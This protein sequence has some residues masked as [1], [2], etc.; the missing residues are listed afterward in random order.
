MH[1][2]KR[3]R[4]EYNSNNNRDRLTRDVLARQNNPN[5]RNEVTTLP[6]ELPVVPTVTPEQMYSNFEE[7]IKMATDNKINAKNSWNFA[8][9][10]YFHEMTFIREGDSINFQRASCT[11]DGCVKIYTSRVDSVASETGKLLTGLAN[12]S[13]DGA[14]GGDLDGEEG[15][16]ERRVR[17]RAHRS[18]ATLLKDF[19]S[20]VLKKLDVDFAVDPL[21]KKTSADF[22]EGGAR[23]LLLN[24]LNLDQD[25]KIIF[26]S[27]DAR[28]EDDDDGDADISHTVLQPLSIKDNN[29]PNNTTH[30]T[31]DNEDISDTENNDTMDIDKERDLF[32]NQ[33]AMG[34]QLITMDDPGEQVFLSQD[35]IDISSLK[36]K[37]RMDTSFSDLQICPTLNGVNFFTDDVIFI[38]GLDDNDRAMDDANDNMNDDQDIHPMD[39][40]GFDGFDYG[41]DNAFDN[42]DQELMDPFADGDDNEREG[43]S[44]GDN[45]NIEIDLTTAISSNQENELLSYFDTTLSKNWAGPEH[46]KLRKPKTKKHPDETSTSEP[47]PKK[48]ASR[49]T[50]TIDF[51]EGEDIDTDEIFANKRGASI[52]LGHTKDHLTYLLPDDEH[53]SSKQLLRYFIKP[54]YSITRW[55]NNSFRG[56]SVEITDKGKPADGLDMNQ[57]PDVGYWANHQDT[58]ESYADIDFG[59]DD[60]NFDFNDDTQYDDTP[61]H[62]DGY[63]NNELEANED[64]TIYDD[65]LITNAQVRKTKTP[66]VNYAKTAKRVDVRKLK[67]NLWK[68]LT[69]DPTG[70]GKTNNDGKV[71]GERRFSD[72][73]QDL[74]KM[75]PPRV[76]KDISVPFCFICVLHLANE[77]NLMIEGLD[78]VGGDDLVLGEEA[79][80]MSNEQMLNEIKI[81]QVS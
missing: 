54:V 15:V 20:L 34:S 78:R 16:T 39:D 25:C 28:P 11:L 5:A 80:W 49:V 62:E 45:N 51:L 36:A 42:N 7:W 70:G 19:S 72:V 63:D 13:R 6:I 2:Y 44:E 57:D 37:M 12:H 81:I 61:T 9:I 74:K 24:H 76:M 73:L 8:L 33:V 71:Y 10:D 17:R 23:G 4:N 59:H 50:F 41:D 58:N 3:Q 75:Y 48:A 35:S 55:K 69:I 53:F 68:A 65:Q 26:D 64:S 43:T 79:P 52:T 46:W 30:S 1:Q 22:D 47:T 60:T 56:N 21:F 27:S 14:E 31:S 29:I 77:Q 40:F 18:E 66:Y 67:D 32:N 38:P